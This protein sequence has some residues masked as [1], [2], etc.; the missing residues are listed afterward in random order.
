MLCFLACVV[1]TGLAVLHALVVN[2]D[3]NAQAPSQD[4]RVIPSDDVTALTGS[5]TMAADEMSTSHDEP[6]IY[7]AGESAHATMSSVHHHQSDSSG[8]DL[9]HRQIAHSRRRSQHRSATTRQP[10]AS[11]VVA[12]ALARFDKH[13]PH[14]DGPV[15]EFRSSSEVGAFVSNR[16][17]GILTNSALHDLQAKRLVSGG[18]MK[19]RA[20]WRDKDRWWRA[21][22]SLHSE[23]KVANP[24][25]RE[26]VV[27]KVD[28]PSR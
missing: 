22:T 4:A 14:M 17:A 2:V 28:L 20:A 25:A 23:P 3:A 7:Q 15:E 24:A 19:R 16:Q 26:D 10:A 27:S 6:A 12:A 5:Q 8:V 11:S 9:L 1:I 21:V 18:R 13:F